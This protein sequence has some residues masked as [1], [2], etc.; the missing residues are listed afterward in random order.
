MPSILTSWKE[1][2]DHLGKGVRT[3][4][5]WEAELALPV[6]RSAGGSARTIFAVPEELDAWAR[7]HPRAPTAATAGSLEREMASLREGIRE[8]R[9]QVCCL[10]DRLND[11]ERV[12]FGFYPT[13][14]GGRTRNAAQHLRGR[15]AQSSRAESAGTPEDQA[16]RGESQEQRRTNRPGESSEARTQRAPERRKAKAR[17]SSPR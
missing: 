9:E 15:S 10:R 7:S 14:S 2:S 1:I 11:L 13:A 8:M 5:R 6:H 3:V 16:L 4:Q 17:V 12:R